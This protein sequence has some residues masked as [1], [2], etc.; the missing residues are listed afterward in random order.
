MLFTII[1]YWWWWYFQRI[2]PVATALSEGT[3]DLLVLLYYYE[4]TAPSSP[5]PIVIG[6]FSI[7]RRRCM[8][9]TEIWNKLDPLSGY[10]FEMA[11]SLARQAHQ[12]GF[13]ALIEPPGSYYSTNH[14]QAVAILTMTGFYYA[15]ER[16]RM[17]NIFTFR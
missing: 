15:R 4:Q 6:N 16:V 13:I 1:T 10:S 2:D 12:R 8:N 7:S 11:Y 9:I 14:H 17:G 5:P 3:A